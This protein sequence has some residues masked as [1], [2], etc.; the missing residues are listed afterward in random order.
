MT[1]H[2]PTG[3]AAVAGVYVARGWHPFPLPAAAKSPPPDGVTGANGIDPTAEQVQRWVELHDGANVGLRMP[4]NVVGID[5]DEYDGKH[6]AA[7]LAALEAQY[8]KLPATWRST[9]RGDGPSGIRFY[10]IPPGVI[11]PG[12]FGPDIEAIQH[13]H[14][15]AVVAPSIHPK[16]GE[17]YRWFDLADV[18]GTNPPLVDDLAELPFAWIEGLRWK[19]APEQVA[20]PRHPLLAI[21]DDSIAD[22]IRNENQWHEVLAGDGWQSVRVDPGGSSSW[23]RPGKD[24]R[25][26][27]SA[28]LHEPDGPFV[29]F[30]TSVAELQP[31]WALNDAGTGWSFSIFG[32][33]AATRHGGDRSACAREY[34]RQTNAVDGK[35]HIMRTSAQ[36]GVVLSGASVD[37]PDSSVEASHLIHWP[38]FWAEDRTD[39]DFVAYPLIPRGRAVALYAPAKAGKS[40]IVLALVAALATGRPL[41][42]STLTAPVDVLYLDYEMTESDLMERLVE[43][44]YDDSTDLSRLHYALMPSLPPLDTRQGAEA[45]TRLA[46]LCGAQLIVVDTFGRAV[47]GDE[48]EADTSRAFYRHTGMMLKAAGRSVLRTDHAGKDVAKGQRGS[49]AKNDDVDVV[50]Q[51]TRSDVGVT[52]VRTHSRVSWVPETVELTRSIDEDAGSILWTITKG[53]VAWPAGTAACVAEIEALGLAPVGY[54][55]TWAALKAAGS[56]TPRLVVRAAL[57]ARRE[58]A[59]GRL[60]LGQPNREMSANLGTAH[61]AAHPF[62]DDVGA[63]P[64]RTTAH[65]DETPAQDTRRTSRRTPAHP[66]EPEG[67]RRRISIYGAPRLEETDPKNFEGLIEPV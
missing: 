48:N 65:L 44:G 58:V 17:R 33:L 32:Y 13:H 8:G 30:S 16:T 5:V 53:D 15:Y 25:H 39:E 55:P 6:G 18:L 50:W 23:T 37:E 67:V 14:R 3:F 12:Q 52:L 22:R 20:L 2:R 19:V 35:L 36:A 10:R 66:A 56:T 9:A 59:A 62:S 42:G 60:S 49:S 61:P 43:L 21:D 24:P 38:S 41:F 57:K 40:T 51:L 54:R 4:L 63:A 45:L 28:V 64:R 27:I 34:R 7:T 46:N 26:G 29:V 31:A 47:E 11:F 1:A